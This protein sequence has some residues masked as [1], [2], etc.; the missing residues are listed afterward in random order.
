MAVLS[1]R[2][3]MVDSVPVRLLLRLVLHTLFSLPSDAGD[4]VYR[5]DAAVFAGV[6]GAVEV[7]QHSEAL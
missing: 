5:V 6:L 7:V 3:R 2:P 1:I 4:Q